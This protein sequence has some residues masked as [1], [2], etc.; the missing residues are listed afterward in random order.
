MLY[1]VVSLLAWTTVIPLLYGISQGDIY[2]LQE[3][4]QLYSQFIYIHVFMYSYS[5]IYLPISRCFPSYSAATHWL[6]PKHRILFKWLMH[7]YKSQHGTAPPAWL[8]FFAFM[9]M[10]GRGSCPHLINLP[11]KQLS[12]PRV[13]VTKHSPFAGPKEWNKIPSH[14]RDSQS[15]HIFKKLLQTHLF[16]LNTS[17]SHKWLLT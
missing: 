11:Y 3:L 2:G 5:F 12:Q 6:P 1:T 14:I 16:A 10:V 9:N 8:N 4:I 7:V 15:I 13:Q 17:S